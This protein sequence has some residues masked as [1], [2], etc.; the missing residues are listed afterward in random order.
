MNSDANND[1][2]QMIM[3]EDFIQESLKDDDKI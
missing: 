1:G 2:F 3:D